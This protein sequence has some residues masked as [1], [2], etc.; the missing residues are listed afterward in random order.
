MTQLISFLCFL[1][2]VVRTGRLCLLPIK[3]YRGNNAV[4]VSVDLIGEKN[5]VTLEFVITI[6]NRQD[7]MNMT[8]RRVGAIR[9]VYTQDAPTP[10]KLF[11]GI[12]Y[13]F[14]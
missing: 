12:T 11:H 6:I 4:F 5:K 9:F 13:N 14:D 2:T 8:T 3:F 1:L 10:N 7:R